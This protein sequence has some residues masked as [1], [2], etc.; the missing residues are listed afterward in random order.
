MALAV[1]AVV[2]G[3]T[4]V[5][6]GSVLA[7]G[8]TTSSHVTWTKLSPATSPTTR[9][10]A[11]MAYNPSSANMV[12]FGGFDAT[13]VLKDTWTWNGTTWTK[14]SPATSPTARYLASMAYDTAT[15]TMVLFGGGTLVS[16]YSDTWT[17]NGTTWTKQS[18][19]TSPSARNGAA[20][21][22]DAATGTMV[23]F[24]GDASTGALG[25]T[26]TWN[27][28][29]WTKQSPATS[30]TA[31]YGAS[32]VY[33]ASTGNV[34]LFGGYNGS[35]RFADTWTWNGTTWTKLS[36]ATSPTARSG[37]SMAYVPAIGGAVLFGGHGTV[38][39]HLAD[40]WTWNGTTWTKLSPATSPTA[41]NGASLAYD[42]STSTSV[43][44]GGTASSGHLNDTWNLSTVPGKPAKPTATGGTQKATVT[45]TAP[46]VTGGSPITGYTVT[47]TP[48]AKTCVVGGT[49][50]TCTVTGLKVNTSYTFKVRAKNAN[51]T[52]ATSTAST[53]VTT[54]TV[55]GKPAKPVALGGNGTAK[56]TWTAPASNGGSP[57]TGYTVT[58]SP[59]A[60]TCTGAATATSC[61]VAG[62][63]NGAT[64]T[65][66]VRAKNVNGTGPTSTASTPVTPESPTPGYLSVSCGTGPVEK[67]ATAVPC[68]TLTLG[69]VQLNGKNQVRTAPMHQLHIST[70]RGRATDNWSLYA[71]M[72]PSSKTLTG[73]ASCGLVRGFCNATTTNATTV[74]NDPSNTSILAKYLTLEGFTCATANPATSPY[75]SN[76][77]P[78]THPGLAVGNVNG[79]SQ[80]LLLCTAA[81][82][83]SGGDFVVGTGVYSLVVPPNVYAGTYYGT[84]QYT[85]VPGGVT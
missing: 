25:D 5:Q 75:A 22:Y 36:P 39:A 66:T 6:G 60:K 31:R 20:M 84:V 51:G 73:N 16:N 64:Y 43:L 79:L 76:P 27:G 35:K 38:T 15:S 69:A 46:T 32:M 82:G 57:I 67:P 40:T 26:W 28:T 2:A 42:P 4:A 24:G 81:A 77:Q 48:T 63:R 41:R 17:W 80:P 11:D 71:E 58:S 55:P 47:S 54:T 72:V 9:Y 78:T 19:A 14:L 52:G 45:W 13:T 10:D 33:D 62:L 50:T 21:A 74:A 56:V 85:L 44:F 61:T 8:A 70:T 23:L 34:V 83:S 30:P 18:P 65:F 29:T 37:A 53:A 49:A 68:A 1:V 12:L 59:T 3:C 7:V